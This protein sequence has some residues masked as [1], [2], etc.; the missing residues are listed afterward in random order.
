MVHG[1]DLPASSR[2]GSDGQDAKDDGGS[3][4]L[5]SLCCCP[6]GPFGRWRQKMGSA[7]CKSTKWWFSTCVLSGGITHTAGE[8]WKGEVYVMKHWAWMSLVWATGEV[9]HRA[10]FYSD[11]SRENTHTNLFQ[12]HFGGH[13]CIEENRSWPQHSHRGLLH[14]PEHAQR[15]AGFPSCNLPSHREILLHDCPQPDSSTA[16]SPCTSSFP[17]TQTKFKSL[18]LCWIRIKHCMQRRGN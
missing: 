14:H 10:F 2:A 5:G 9:H 17:P 11:L 12:Q 18:I 13:I 4:V 1:T 8:H 16:K 3:A 6:L 15:P 7:Q